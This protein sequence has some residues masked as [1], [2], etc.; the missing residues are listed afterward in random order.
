MAASGGVA[1][2][3][4]QRFK[5]HRWMIDNSRQGDLRHHQKTSAS[6]LSRQGWRNDFGFTYLYSPLHTGSSW[7]T[8]YTFSFNNAASSTPALVAEFKTP[9]SSSPETLRG[10]GVTPL[11]NQST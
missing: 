11:R 10:N 5:T 1:V 7:D 6:S 8:G 9:L 3:P 2:S 4:I